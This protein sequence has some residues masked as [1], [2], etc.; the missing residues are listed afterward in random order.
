M[1][2]RPIET[3]ADYDWALKEIERYF[4]QEPQP[5]TEDARRFDNLADLVRQ[6]EDQHYPIPRNRPDM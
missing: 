3:E 5:G 6:Y 1:D 2:I 4:E